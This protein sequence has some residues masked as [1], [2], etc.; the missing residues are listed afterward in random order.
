M[1]EEKNEFDLQLLINDVYLNY[2]RLNKHLNK[3]YPTAFTEFNS[4]EPN[5]T[6]YPFNYFEF[7]YGF[8]LSFTYGETEALN[9]NY[10]GTFKYSIR[11]TKEAA[12]KLGRKNMDLRYYGINTKY[13]AVEK[14]IDKAFEIIDNLLTGKE[15]PEKLRRV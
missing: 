14:L 8:D 6:E 15:M 3:E 9:P 12:I 1:E 13:K 11:I 7:F 5:N 10:T 2:D 4:F